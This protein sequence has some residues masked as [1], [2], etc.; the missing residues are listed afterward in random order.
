MKAITAA[1]TA[2]ATALALAACGPDQSGTFEDENGQT[3]SYA[4]DQDD[5]VTRAEVRTADGTATMESGASVAAKL[6]AGFSVY[7]G[8]RVV[9]ATNIA[10]PQG[11]GTL[12]TFETADLP[13][14]LN[15]YY[16][17]QAEAAGIAI[18]VEMTVEDGTMLAGEGKDGLGFS[19]NTSRAGDTTNA[20]M[21]V[22]G[23][24]S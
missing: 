17:K 16:K 23:K 24:G 4:V 20:T 6:P 12:V 2:A 9:S 15:G 3:G 1:A 13:E 7:P 21:M 14:K 19:L 8:A 5:G 11:N 18:Q 10:G 22:G